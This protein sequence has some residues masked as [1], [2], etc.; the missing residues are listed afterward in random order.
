MHYYYY[1][2]LGQESF[3]LEVYILTSETKN[4]RH[5]REGEVEEKEK[6]FFFAGL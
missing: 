3:C 6:M 2:Y 1:Y 4:L 5:K